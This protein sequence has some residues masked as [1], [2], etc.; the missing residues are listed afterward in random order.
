MG[1]R[2]SGA[3]MNASSAPGVPS[4][5]NAPKPKATAGSALAF[6]YSNI[7]EERVDA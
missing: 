3:I 5:R 7:A 2:V 4:S 6:A 1:I